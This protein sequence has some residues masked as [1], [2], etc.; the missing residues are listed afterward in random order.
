VSAL[1]YLI[2]KARKAHGNTL[3]DEEAARRDFLWDEVMRCKHPDRLAAL[4]R[5]QMQ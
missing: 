5:L 3:S 2:R 4:W 1:I